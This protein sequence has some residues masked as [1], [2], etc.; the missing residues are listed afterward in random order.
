MQKE[1]RFGDWIDLGCEGEEG[2]KN[3]LKF[4]LTFIKIGIIRTSSGK[5]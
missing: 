1:D 3:D 2:I 4:P 5:R